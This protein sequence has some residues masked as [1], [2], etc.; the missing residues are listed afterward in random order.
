MAKLITYI[1]DRSPVDLAQFVSRGQLALGMTVAMAGLASL[2][3]RL[4]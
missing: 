1:D 2:A 4:L 3:A